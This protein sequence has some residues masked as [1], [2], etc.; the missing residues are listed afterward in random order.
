MY[1]YR[2]LPARIVALWSP[3]RRTTAPGRSYRARTARM[4]SS[5]SRPP[6]LLRVTRTTPL[7]G[8]RRSRRPSRTA[9]TGPWRPPVET[10]CVNAAVRLTAATSPLSTPSS[11][12]VRV[13]DPPPGGPPP[14]RSI[15]SGPPLRLPCSRRSCQRSSCAWHMILRQTD[16]AGRVPKHCP[17]G[18]VGVLQA[19][20]LIAGSQCSSARRVVH[21]RQRRAAVGPARRRRAS[22]AS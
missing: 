5:T 17:S 8:R 20:R 19:A 22:S 18:L 21:R 15:A 9:S 10:Y 14:S 13:L 12:P 2:R 3:R 7:P 1:A 6:S 4:R 16:R 11:E